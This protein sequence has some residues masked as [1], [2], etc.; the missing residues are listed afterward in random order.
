MNHKRWTLAILA[1]ALAVGLLAGTSVAAA[2]PIDRHACA[3]ASGAH[4]RFD[5]RA[6]MVDAANAYFKNSPVPVISAVDLLKAVVDKDPSYQIVDVRSAEHFA[7]GHID[8]A[9]NIPFRTIVDDASLAKLDS[10]KTIVTVCYT[11]ET[12]SMTNMV[13]N[14]LGYDTTTLMYGMSGWVADKA[15]VGIDIPSGIAAGYPTTTVPTIPTRTYRAPKLE[16]SYRNVA[17]AVKGQ[18]QAY[19][20]KNL[21]PV[22]TATEVNAVVLSKNPHYQIVSVRQ[23]AAY[24][25]G[26]IAGAQNI[27]WTD[28]ADQMTKLDPRKTTIVYCYTGNTGAQAAMFLNIM[29]YES[30]NMMSGISSWNSDPAVGG[31]VGFNPAN[32]MNYY[33]VR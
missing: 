9:I 25:T 19:F 5:S 28:I 6:A 27:V 30:Y 24:A 14:M 20:A 33:T 26:H 16:G 29:G 15:I 32:A 10:T 22:M 11:G 8:G 3:N 7:L 18:T 23:T 13:W 4:N 31:L 17:D 2:R 21:A 12:A 1:G